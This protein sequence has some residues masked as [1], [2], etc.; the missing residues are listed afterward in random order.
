MGENFGL[1]F[2]HFPNDMACQKSYALA[3]ELWA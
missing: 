3:G 1:G 2:P